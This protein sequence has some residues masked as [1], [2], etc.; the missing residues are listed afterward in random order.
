MGKLMAFAM[1]LVAG[2]VAAEPFEACVAAEM[3]AFET[4]LDDALNAQ[5]APNFD[6]VDGCAV[7]DCAGIALLVCEGAGCD[8]VASDVAELAQRFVAAVPEPA[9]VRGLNPVW[10]DGLYPRLWVEAVPGEGTEGLVA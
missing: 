3:A 6:L 5:A 10:S 2:P 1:A 7:G 9:A 8:A 4:R